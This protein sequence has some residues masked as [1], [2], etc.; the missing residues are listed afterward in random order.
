[1]PLPHDLL[2]HL[3]REIAQ[4]SGTAAAIVSH[5]PIGGGSI[6][7]CY[8]LETDAGRLFVKVNA[9]DHFP[10][11][12]EAEADGLRRLRE[13]GPLRVPS[14]MAYG[15][16]DGHGYLLMEWIEYGIKGPGFWEDL[17]RGL[18]KLHRHTQERFGLD[19]DNCIGSLVQRNSPEH[20]WPT[21]FIRHRLEAQLRMARDKHRVADGMAFRFERLFAR[22]DQIFPKEP[23]ALL[24]GD[25]WSGNFLCD[26][27]SRPVL[28]DP[29]VYYGHREMDLAMTRLFGG[30]EDPFY[31]AYHAEWPLAEGWKERVDLC[32]LYPLM[33]HVNLFGGGYTTQ[34]EA[35]LKRFA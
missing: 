8:R 18:A 34:V 23:P 5:A 7:D 14:V 19:R 15:E 26:A 29:A 21:F 22:L 33:V 1:M 31:A 11:L 3:A 2:E 32:N 35:I 30:F 25:L 12:F 20:E 13:A 24:H 17:G 27:N 28:I 9:A 16:A 10:S 4:R 6:N